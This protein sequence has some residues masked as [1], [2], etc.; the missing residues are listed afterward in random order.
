MMSKDNLDPL[1]KREFEALG[2]NIVSNDLLADMVFERVKKRRIQKWLIAGAVMLSLLGLA[3]LSYVVGTSSLFSSRE[4]VIQSNSYQIPG[5]EKGGLSLPQYAN[6]RLNGATLPERTYT[7]TFALEPGQ[8]IEIFTDPHEASGGL[9]A[10][11]TIYARDSNGERVRVQTY[12][13]GPGA[14]NNEFGNITVAGLYD[15]EYVFT[16][17]S[18]RG[19]VRVGILLGQFS[20]N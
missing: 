14:H 2:L 17:L 3:A 9:I 13:I 5:D 15:F 10:E 1:I 12:P 16:D 4:P 6:L 11:L 20:D 8:V 19:S 7:F 18:Y